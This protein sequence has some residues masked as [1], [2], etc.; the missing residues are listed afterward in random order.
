MSTFVVVACNATVYRNSHLTTIRLALTSCDGR[1][2]DIDGLS[3]EWRDVHR[4]LGEELAKYPQM[5]SGCSCSPCQ[6]KERG[7]R[8]P[9][10]AARKDY[11]A[12]LKR[13]ED[14]DLV[15]RQ[16]SS[17]DAPDS[18]RVNSWTGEPLDNDKQR[19]RD[20]DTNAILSREAADTAFGVFARMAAAEG[21]VA[22]LDGTMREKDR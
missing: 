14:A 2:F 8:R 12:A 9:L 21:M 18:H 22:E 13:A 4:R 20:A 15:A 1:R 5:C 19:S 16:L 3:D 11:L 10:F 7:L 6:C 17:D